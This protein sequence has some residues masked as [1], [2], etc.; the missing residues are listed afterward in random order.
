MC[1]F[2]IISSDLV[3]AAGKNIALFTTREKDDMFWGTVA[4]FMDEA[5]KDLG[6]VLTH[7]PVKQLK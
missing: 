7:I 3:V 6:M 4:N 1:T 2:I 5:C